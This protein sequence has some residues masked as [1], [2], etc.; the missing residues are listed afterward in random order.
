M[1]LSP[2][3]VRK[4]SA[5]FSP[6]QH[7]SRILWCDSYPQKAFRAISQRSRQS[8][9]IAYHEEKKFFP[10]EATKNVTLLP[11]TR[12]FSIRYSP[13]RSKRSPL[14][15]GRYCADSVSAVSPA[16]Q[17]RMAFVYMA[18]YYLTWVRRIQNKTQYCVQCT[19]CLDTHFDIRTGPKKQEYAIQNMFHNMNR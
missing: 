19:L 3:F 11:V 17:V 16:T 6:Y 1:F 2:L 7:L 9:P 13:P 4:D 15:A 8:L 18:V 10:P 12:L 14:V 5:S